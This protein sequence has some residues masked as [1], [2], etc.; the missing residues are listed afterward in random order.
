M[1]RIA[2]EAKAHWG[3]PAEELA[4][5]SA[6]LRV[7]PAT[8]ELWPTFVAEAGDAVIGWAQLD[9]RPMPWALD[10]LWVAPDQMGRGVGRSL[11]THALEIAAAAG[12][13]VLTIDA[14]PHAEGFYLR[15]GA[16]RRA[17]VAAPIASDPHRCR[18]QLVLETGL[19][20]DE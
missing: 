4:R 14:D 12:Q 1:N 17:T 11:L 10:A 8:I 19:S 5:W 16:R 9:P 3:Y 20:C 6:D 13:R 15:F 2:L 7:T 18:P